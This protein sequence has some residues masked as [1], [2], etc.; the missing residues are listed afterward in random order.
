MS[1]TIKNIFDI[2][3]LFDKP[4]DE[5][6]SSFISFNSDSYSVKPTKFSGSHQES[7]SKSDDISAL[8]GR[9]QNKYS[10]NVEQKHLNQMYD[11][12]ILITNKKFNHQKLVPKL[13]K[14]IDERANDAI[15][16]I[17]DH[18][19]S[20]LID[21]LKT[22]IADG[23]SETYRKAYNTSNKYCYTTDILQKRAHIDRILDEF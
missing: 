11:I 19:R 6:K 12:G 5:D 21:A 13:N 18:K 23:M 15:K 10:G 9:I 8:I 7:L 4:T 22:G 17:R 16:K 14:I 2:D 1:E 20:M 3:D